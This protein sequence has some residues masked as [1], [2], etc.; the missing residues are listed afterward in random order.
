M[1]DNEYAVVTDKKEISTA[2]PG[3]PLTSSAKFMRGHGTYI[4][5]DKVVS[6]VAGV[7]EQINK[8]VTVRAL[9]ARYTGEI[10]DVVVG[11][12][13]ELAQKRW[14]VDVNS[15]QDAILMLSAIH[16]PGGVQRRKSESDELRMTTFFAEGDLIVAEIQA[17]F[18]DGA[19]S[20]HTRNLKYGKL[21]N[22]TLVKIPPALVQRS[23]SHFHTLPCGVDV[24]LGVNGYI[25]ICKHTPLEV[26]EAN[27]ENIYSSQN[28][29]ISETDRSNIARVAN[30]ILA[31]SHQF[32]HI[33]E[34]AIVYAF[35]ASLPFA[36]KDLLSESVANEIAVE[37]KSKLQ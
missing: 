35:E 13:T 18:A 34:T 8:L 3:E 30:C 29:A 16:L 25:W 21:R 11:R 23:R 32:V 14:K 9:K 24:I 33:H 37:T 12:I 28:D 17:F 10:G 20:I 5:N 19:I 27:P 26:V 6:A 1:Q 2:T 15:R 31:L 7:V 36:I 4:E 22:G